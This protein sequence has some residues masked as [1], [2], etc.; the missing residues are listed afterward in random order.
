M[1]ERAD[2]GGRVRVPDVERHIII[3]N[4]YE[5]GQ[6]YARNNDLPVP[7]GKLVRRDGTR[8][9]VSI[10]TPTTSDKV[11]RGVMNPIV[12]EAFD[13]TAP[14]WPWEQRRNLEAAMA[15]TNARWVS[16]VERVRR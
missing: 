14:G 13:P 3:A 8:V 10:I 16:A 15:V 1:A 2:A 4:T 5:I 9:M 6:L 11:T 7:P 12:H